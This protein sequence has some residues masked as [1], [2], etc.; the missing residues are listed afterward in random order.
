MK[1]KHIILVVVCVFIAWVVFGIVSPILVAK[2]W[3][4]RGA[5]GD[6]FGGI[7]ALFSGLAFAGVVIAILLQKEELSLQRLE[8]SETRIELRRSAKAQEQLLVHSAEQAKALSTATE[9][10]TLN[11]LLDYY[12]KELD[13]VGNASGPG[14]ESQKVR[15]RSK[16]SAIVQQLEV[17]HSQL[18]EERQ[19]DD[20]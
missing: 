16:T 2:D 9:L 11:N 5:F 3:D 13:R 15:L 10:S 4:G 19:N 12:Q 20:S 17:I 7:N 1:K 14:P 8:L 6:M 18:A